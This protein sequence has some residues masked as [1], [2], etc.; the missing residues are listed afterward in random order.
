[1][2]PPNKTLCFILLA[3]ILLF[4]VPSG[5]FG[6]A[7][8]VIQNPIGH[9]SFFGLLTVVVKWLLGFVAILALLAM[10][11]GGIRM[12]TSFGNEDSVR[13]GKQILTW[14]IV[15]LAVVVLSYTILNIIFSNLI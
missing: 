2:A 5:V 11:I 1:M 8:S 4:L 12:I 10:V 9:N 13:K 7:V 14:A 6:A 15:G 3:G